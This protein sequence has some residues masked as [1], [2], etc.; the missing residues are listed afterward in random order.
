MNIANQK[1]EIIK[2]ILSIEDQ[3]IIEQLDD[4]RKQKKINFKD[5]FK[6]AITSED[7]KKRTTQF[8]SGLVW[9][10]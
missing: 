9:E 3:K 5:E 6:N 4:F 7:L 2:W 8:L 10:K 1:S